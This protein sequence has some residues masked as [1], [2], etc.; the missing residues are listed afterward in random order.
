MKNVI[1]CFGCDMMKGRRMW[2]K[3]YVD[4]V[5]FVELM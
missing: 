3:I 5:F 4:W 2:L 1:N